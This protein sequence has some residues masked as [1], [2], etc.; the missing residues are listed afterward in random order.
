M[1]YG[2]EEFS[3]GDRV[4]QD[5]AWVVN[6]VNRRASEDCSNSLNASSTTPIIVEINYL[7]RELYVQQ[8]TFSSEMIIMM[9][10]FNSALS[11]QVEEI[12]AQLEF[13]VLMH[14]DA[15]DIFVLGGLEEIQASL[16]E[17]C[18]HISTI[19]SS[20][21]CGPIKS[22]VEEWSKNLDLFSKTLVI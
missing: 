8:W 21:N 7:F 18:I 12:W 2:A 14:K 4:L 15:R 16:D 20:R 22:R 19:L 10:I 17:S 13:P 3:S 6:K 9:T 1:A 5:A 11:Q